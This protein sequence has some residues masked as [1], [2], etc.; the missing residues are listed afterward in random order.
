MP[1][2]TRRTRKVGHRLVQFFDSFYLRVA[3]CQPG[4][5]LLSLEEKVLPPSGDGSQGRGRKGVR[6]G[7][8][9]R[10]LLLCLAVGV[11][12][13]HVHS[14]GGLHWLPDVGG[15]ILHLYLFLGTMLVYTVTHFKDLSF[16]SFH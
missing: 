3:V 11:Q 16:V 12:V 14:G 15:Y 8:C 10:F 6:G 9:L 13:C 4:S 7:W 2:C 1:P 5:L